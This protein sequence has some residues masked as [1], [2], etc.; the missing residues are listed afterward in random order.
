MSEVGKP[1]T[2]V[3]IVPEREPV[4]EKM[5]LPAVEPEPVETGKEKAPA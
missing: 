5:P 2:T 3:T 4:P 1:T